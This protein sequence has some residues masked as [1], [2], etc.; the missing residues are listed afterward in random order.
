LSS[1]ASSATPA[2]AASFPSSFR[3]TTNSE[4]KHLD[5][6]AHAQSQV[7]PHQ[8]THPEADPCYGV[9]GGA[10]GEARGGDGLGE[11]SARAA[12]PAPADAPRH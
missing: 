5:R 7:D 11:L 3:S 1:P 8:S 2:A 9:R 10:Q 12:P 4:P 6:S